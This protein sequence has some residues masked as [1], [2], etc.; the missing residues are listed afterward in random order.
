MNIFHMIFLRTWRDLTQLRHFTGKFIDIAHGEVD[1][2]F[3]RRRQQMQYGIGGAAHGDIQRHGVF[4]RRLTGDITRQRRG[5]VLLVVTFS[6]LNDTRARIEEQLLAIGVSRQQR[7][8][9]RL[10]Q[11]QRFGQ[12]VH[13]VRGEHP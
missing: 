12:A 1:F 3:L 10:R 4:K 13:G 2:R 11:A 6:Q 9:T 5:V 8:V 7:A